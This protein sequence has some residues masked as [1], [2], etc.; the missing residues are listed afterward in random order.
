MREAY[1]RLEQLVERYSGIR[2][3]HRHV[4][5][6]AGG[7]RRDDG[8]FAELRNATDVWGPTLNRRYRT[9]ERAWPRD[10]RA[11]LL[12]LVTADNPAPEPWVPTA[13]E[14]DAALVAYLET[15][16]PAVPLNAFREMF[17]R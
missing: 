3:A 10:P 7:P 1:G 17:S 12:W 11:Y 13:A 4:R 5:A 9:D 6:I 8:L 2:T 15:K 14:Q 16:A